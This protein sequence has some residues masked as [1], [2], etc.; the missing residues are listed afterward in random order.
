MRAMFSTSLWNSFLSESGRNSR[1]LRW[2]PGGAASASRTG[3]NTIIPGGG[4]EGQRI[5]RQRLK[6]NHSYDMMI[7][8][9]VK[10]ALYSVDIITF[11]LGFSAPHHFANMAIKYVGMLYGT[12]VIFCCTDGDLATLS[13]CQDKAKW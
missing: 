12:L 11:P 3:L 7:P 2:R 1:G 5:C 9:L 8:L 4:K 13:C 6:K 10:L